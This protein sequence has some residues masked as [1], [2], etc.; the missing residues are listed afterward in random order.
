MRGKVWVVVVLL[1]F[2]FSTPVV[3][4]Q[5][6]DEAEM[7]KLIQQFTHLFQQGKYPEAVPLGDRTLAMSEKIF[8]PEHQNTAAA[9]SNLARLY[10]AMGDYAHALPLFERT[11]AIQKK[12]L[13]PD[14]LDTAG[15]V[16]NLA[17]VY[18]AMGDYAHALLLH[19][20]A[21]E[22]Y[23]KVL[24]AEHPDIAASV[25]NLAQLYQAMGDY[26]RA[27]PLLQRALAIYEKVLGA[28]H[29]NTAAALNNLASL[30]QAMGDYAHALPLVQ[31][32]LAIQEKVLGFDH[33]DTAASATNLAILY[34]TMGDSAHALPLHQR[35]LVIQE[36][37]LGPE[38]PITVRG[39]NDL[40]VLYQAMG[41]YAH[42]LPLHQQVLAIQ[43]KVL[44]PEHPDTGT[45]AH[46]LAGA[47]KE[48]GDYTHAL[49]LYE[50]ALVIQEKVLGPEHPD[51]ARSLNNLAILYQAKGDYAQ[52]LLFF[53]RGLSVEDQTL[54]NVFAIATEEQK[55]QFAQQSQ[56]NYFAA[57]SLIGAQLATDPVALRLGLEWV[58]RRKGIVLTA[59]ARMQQRLATHLHG[60]ELEAWQRLT[61]HRSELSRLLLINAPPQDPANYRSTVDDL[62][63]AITREEE[64]LAQRTKVVA[65]E[66]VQRR[67]TVQ[68]LADHLPPKSA[69]IEFVSIPDYD[70]KTKK[71]TDTYHYLAFVLTPDAR[72]T[73][74]DVGESKKVNAAIRAALVAIAD[75][76]FRHDLKTHTSNVDSQLT[77][78]YTL[79][80][81]PLEAAL[82]GCKWLVVSPDGELSK[83]PFAAL[84]TPEGHYLI[85]QMTVSYVASGRDLL[86]G[87]SEDKPTTDLLL[88]SNPAF[89]DQKVLHQPTG[90]EDAVR[91]GDYSERFEPLPGTAEEARV[92]PTLLSGSQQVLQGKEATESALRSAKAPKVLHLA[93]HGFFLKDEKISPPDPRSLMNGFGPS[94]ER[95]KGGLRTIAAGNEH[96]TLQVNPMVRSGL[97]LAGANY[98]KEVKAGDDGLLT[99]L[100]VSGM[101]LYSTDLVVLS[102][103]ETGVGDVQVGEG[104]YGL[105]RAFVL[106][107]AK[108]LVM[109]LWAVN[110]KITLQQMEEFYRGYAAGKSPAVALRAAQLK[111]IAALREQTKAKLGE[112]LAPVRLWAPFIVQQTAEK[113]SG[114]T[115]AT[116]DSEVTTPTLGEDTERGKGGMQQLPTEEP[117]TDQTQDSQK[118]IEPEA[119]S[120]TVNNQDGGIAYQRWNLIVP[121]LAMI[122][123]LVLSRVRVSVV[124]TTIAHEQ[125]INEGASVSPAPYA[126]LLCQSSGPK[127]PQEIAIVRDNLL[128]GSH[129]NCDI[130]LRHSS[131]APQHARLQWRKQGYVLSDLRSPTG[132]YV[133]GRR[134]TENL[135]KEGWVVRL[136]EVEFTFY[137]AM[138]RH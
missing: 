116:T 29:Q 101:N 18:Q 107:G 93:T 77:D 33:P 132:T 65:Q 103:C 8:G 35:A 128:I 136:G 54:A 30:Y 98:A 113:R 21:L 6:E 60:E 84:R 73:L 79:L 49:P 10:Q 34:Q 64:W 41:D 28:D 19:Q 57:L 134:I 16:N 53:Q 36:K 129:S 131:V 7:Q 52:A 95:G 82:G 26:A 12:V 58:L 2:C 109:S 124:P 87:A 115:P 89:D 130:V 42:A 62:R 17:L 24:G 86:R 46:N 1:F 78:L 83:V 39:V 120:L 138:P 104:V 48:T 14:H 88:V 96:P 99:A 133:N 126:R 125:A 92:V 22:I 63:A 40:A 51:T 31:R 91:A 67:V 114:E 100:E 25:N 85:E 3:G 61:Q 97:A 43:E 56:G 127:L 13:G 50:R 70:A 4:G 81:R 118:T 80:L 69:L 108:N 72:V 71:W 90:S 59:Q 94:P 112:P 20:Q 105:R 102:A 11:F 9:L 68:L 23:E 75:P 119:V 55:L 111:S 38:H 27:L 110:D 47:Y 106:A 66:L 74:V 135:L 45:S 137:E 5:K 44:G 37:V 122:G 76:T 117:S 15:T 123:L 32:A 121:F